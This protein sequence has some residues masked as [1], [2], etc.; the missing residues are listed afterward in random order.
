MRLARDKFG[1]EFTETDAK[2][3]AAVAA[4]EWADFR[5]SPEAKYDAEEPT[6]VGRK[7]H[8][9][10]RSHRLALHRTGRQPARAQPR[11]L[12]S[13]RENRRQDQPLS[14]PP[15]P[16]RSRSI[17]C[18]LDDGINIRNAKLQEL[19]HHELLLGAQSMPAA[20]RSPK[21]ST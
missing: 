8:A 10:S 3:F 20:C 14:L 11:H 17:D 21:T 12:D 6:I 7:P 9:Q 2:F 1:D 4:N 15:C 16:S 13:R 5:P 18:L 19:D